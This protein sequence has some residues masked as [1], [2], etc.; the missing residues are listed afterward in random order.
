VHFLDFS[1]RYLNEDG[2]L[3]TELYRND[4]LHLSSEGYRVWADA[5]RQPLKDLMSA[6]TDGE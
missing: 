1:G 3:K 4:L 5:I 2:S 6:D